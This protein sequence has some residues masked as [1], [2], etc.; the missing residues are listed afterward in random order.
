MTRA[1]KMVFISAVASDASVEQGNSASAPT[2]QQ[3][4]ML[5]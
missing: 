1:M 4:H 2:I 3:L 5:E